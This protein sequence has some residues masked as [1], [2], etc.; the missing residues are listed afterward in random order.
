MSRVFVGQN[1]T[2]ISSNP[3]DLAWWF[4]RPLRFVPAGYAQNVNRGPGA[5]YSDSLLEYRVQC[6]HEVRG[7]GG[8]TYTFPVAVYIDNATG[9]A[10]YCEVYGLGCLTYP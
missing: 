2:G 4:P 10:S 6:T 1:L 8:N 3:C 9:R 5:D 7:P